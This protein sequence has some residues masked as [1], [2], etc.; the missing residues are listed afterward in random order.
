MNVNNNNNN[1]FDEMPL[2]NALKQINHQNRKKKI[3]FKMHNILLIYH[4]PNF[5]KF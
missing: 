3:K 1:N 4:I 5:F 2:I